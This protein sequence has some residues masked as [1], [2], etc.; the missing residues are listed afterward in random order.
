MKGQRTYCRRAEVEEEVVPR[1]IRGSFLAKVSAC[2]DGW[3]KAE[4]GDG[5]FF[6]LCFIYLRARVTG[7]K[8]QKE[9][10][11]IC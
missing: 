2:G 11:S 4:F 1:E 8:K 5:F 6:K 9:R 3:R 10:S 7:E